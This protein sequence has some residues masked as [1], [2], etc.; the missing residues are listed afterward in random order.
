VG[1]DWAS[2]TVQPASARGA[3]VTLS[4]IVPVVSF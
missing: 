1:R 3:S 4:V 2:V